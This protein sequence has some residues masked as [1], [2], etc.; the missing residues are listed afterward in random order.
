MADAPPPLDTTIEIVTPEN[1][2]FRHEVA[3]PFRRLPA[4]LIDLLIRWG[5]AI[6]GAIAAAIV[7]SG[8][9]LGSLWYG[10]AL[11]LW[12]VL[13]WFY[14]GLFEA[15]FNG[16]TPGKRLMQIRVV[17]VDGRPISGF[18]AVLRNLLR[19]VDGVGFYLLGLVVAATNDRFQRLGDLVCGT[20]VV[21]EDRQWTPGLIRTGD[22]RIIRLAALLPAR[23]V[24]SRALAA[25]LAAYVQ[26]RSSFALGRRLEIARHLGEP[27]RRRFGLPPDTN[28]DLLLCVLY[29]RTFIADR[30]EEASPTGSPF[31][32]SPFG[33]S[34]FGPSP[35]GGAAA[36]PSAGGPSRPD[37]VPAIMA[38]MDRG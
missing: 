19:V 21:I 32:G 14:G 6:V 23:F 5:M 10:V 35:L 26:R 29:H 2:A 16:Q 7:F 36:P 27:L 22:L 18:Q 8:V 3:G 33:P 11:L 17:T 34:P 37:D 31:E 30:E 28:L 4:Y 20:M 12:F 25:A 15:Y 13:A 24:P 38:A 1:I 9:G